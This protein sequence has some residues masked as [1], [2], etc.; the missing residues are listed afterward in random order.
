MCCWDKV[1]SMLVETGIYHIITAIRCIPEFAG[2]TAVGQCI[3]E[4]NQLV[5]FQVGQL[6]SVSERTVEGWLFCCDTRS[7]M[8][9]HLWYAVNPSIMHIRE[10]ALC[11]AQ[12]WHHEFEGITAFP[13]YFLPADIIEPV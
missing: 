6:N 1:V 9:N 7:V 13:C 4:I 2:E 5:F 11:I 3:Y 10:C 12:A 8:F